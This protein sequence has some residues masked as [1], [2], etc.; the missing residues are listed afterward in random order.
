MAPYEADTQ[1]AYMAHNVVVD[2]V[3]STD[4]DLIVPYR[5]PVQMKEFGMEGKVT[6]CKFADI[7]ADRLYGFGRFTWYQML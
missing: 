6:I 5:I 3:I 1:L 7:E 2:A 4:T